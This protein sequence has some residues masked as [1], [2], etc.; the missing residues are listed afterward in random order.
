[1]PKVVLDEAMKARLNAA[2]GPL[3]L[4]DPSGEI[5][6]HFVPADLYRSLIREW[7]HSEVTDEEIEESRKQTG[8]RPL[9]EIWDRLGHE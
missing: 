2:G 8:G 4:C 3:E 7:L 1:M 6:G 9:S 5:L